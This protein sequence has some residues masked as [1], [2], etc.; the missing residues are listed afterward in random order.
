M[1]YNNV[2]TITDRQIIGG[3]ILLHVEMSI[4]NEVISS[5][6]YLGIRLDSRLKFLYQ[7]QYS[8]NKAQ[9]IVRELSRLMARW[10]LLM[11][12]GNSIMLY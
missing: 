12:V 10:R 2:A 8:I 7:I 6:G 11:E 4:G 5:V 3:R 9:N 1:T